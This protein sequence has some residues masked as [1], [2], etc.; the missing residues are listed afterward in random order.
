MQKE[1]DTK[2]GSPPSLPSMKPDQ[3]FL[4][5]AYFYVRG[6]GWVCHRGNQAS[7][8]ITSFEK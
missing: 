1:Y 6:V 8:T 2:K 7:L 5:C 3:G 4:S